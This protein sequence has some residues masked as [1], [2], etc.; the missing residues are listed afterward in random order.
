MAP[1]TAFMRGQNVEE[2]VFS[3]APPLDGDGQMGRNNTGRPLKSLVLTC[4]LL[5]NESPKILR[6]TAHLYFVCTFTSFYYNKIWN[7]TS[8]GKEP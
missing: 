3:L 5:R 1:P 2:L 4:L 6:N 7:Y 8:W